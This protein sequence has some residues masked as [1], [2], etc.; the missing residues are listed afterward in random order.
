MH[1]VLQRLTALVPLKA[2]GQEYKYRPGRLQEL[3][4]MHVT[5]AAPIWQRSHAPNSFT[6][7][8]LFLQPAAGGG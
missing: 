8:K 2:F 4:T 7:F 5:N 3:K 6:N 1:V